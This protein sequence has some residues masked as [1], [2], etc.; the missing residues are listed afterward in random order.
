MNGGGHRQPFDK[1]RLVDSNAGYPAE[2]KTYQVFF[3]YPGFC[4]AHRPYEPEQ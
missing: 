2:Y 4:F 1:K 3:F